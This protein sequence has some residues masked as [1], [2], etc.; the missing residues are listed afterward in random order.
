MHHPCEVSLQSDP[1][2]YFLI[3]MVT[4]AIGS[5]FE[6][7]KPKCTSTHSKELSCEVSLLLD[8]KK[9]PE[10][11]TFPRGFYSKP[12]NY[13]GPSKYTQMSPSAIMLLIWP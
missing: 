3:V 1:K 7:V 9:I 2:K 11:K 4:M 5:H 10:E 6:N 13:I 8:H 12:P